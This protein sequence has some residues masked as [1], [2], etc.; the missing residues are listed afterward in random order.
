MAASYASSSARVTAS[1]GSS[2]STPRNRG[3]SNSTPRPTRPVRVRVHVQGRGA[4][5]GEHLQRGLA[6]VRLALPG[7]MAHGIH[8]GVAVAVE[9]D[10]Q[11]VEAEADTTRPDVDVVALDDVMDGRVRVV[12]SSDRVD[13]Q[14][15][16]DM[17]PAPD[18]PRRR[19]HR[20]GRQVVERP[21]L[22]IGAPAAPVAHE[23]EDALE[24]G[25][26]HARRRGT[27]PA[28]SSCSWLGDCWSAARRRPGR[29]RLTGMRHGPR[30]AMSPRYRLR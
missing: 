8:V 3:M 25:H 16:R 30:P 21:Q 18:Q 17:S 11:E 13:G 26:I 12:R 9:R 6:V 24:L 5:R 19:D 4:A 2:H 20:P 23:R 27:H 14:R 22:V 1:P 29:R 7:E 10:T 15:H 28:R